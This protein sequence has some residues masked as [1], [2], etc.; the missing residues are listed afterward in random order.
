[1][2]QPYLATL[3]LRCNRS[4]PICIRLLIKKTQ[5]LP[6]RLVNNT[7]YISIFILD[8]L[9]YKIHLAQEASLG[10]SLEDGQGRAMPSSSLWGSEF[11]RGEKGHWGINKDSKMLLFFLRMTK[12]RTRLPV[13]A[14][15]DQNKFTNTAGK[16]KIVH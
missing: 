16:F 11:Q 1:M 8:K 15:S 5:I 3:Y 13:H 9:T 7:I 6:I 4:F 12:S 10:T 2:T 14:R